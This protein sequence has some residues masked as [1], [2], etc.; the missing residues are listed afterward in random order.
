ML[1]QVVSVTLYGP[2]GYLNT[3]AVLDTGNTRS[4][5]LAD[6]AEKLGLD[7]PLEGVLLNGIQKTY[8][9]LTKRIN[10]Q[11]SPVNDFGTQFDVN[12]F[13]LVDHLNLSERKMKLQ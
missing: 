6:V 5:L 13:L 7:G 11:V 3:L 10:V 12:G 8:E 4:L 1:L 9:L 2:K